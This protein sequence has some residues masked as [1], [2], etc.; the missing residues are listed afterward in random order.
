MKELLIFDDGN[1]NCFLAISS[2]DQSSIVF[3]QEDHV[4]LHK[5]TSKP[6]SESHI[7]PI[8]SHNTH[9]IR[10]CLL[11]MATDSVAP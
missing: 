9:T 3:L 6:H 5:K 2:H 10:E 7:L 8:T 1:N 11:V 4:M